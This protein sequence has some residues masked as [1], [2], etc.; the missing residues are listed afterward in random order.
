[1]N[2]FLLFLLTLALTGCGGTSI[3]NGVAGDLDKDFGEGGQALEIYASDDTSDANVSPN[4][5][6]SLPDD[7]I[8]L[9][10][11]VN[12]AFLL[13]KFTSNGVVDTT[14]GTN[15]AAITVFPQGFCAGVSK[16]ILTSDGQIMAGGSVCGKMAI[17]RYNTDGSLDNTYGNGVVAGV[18]IENQLVG[19][20]LQAITSIENS[21]G[22]KVAFGGLV[23]NATTGRDMMVGRLDATG[24]IDTTFGSAGFLILDAGML[25]T[26]I[27]LGLDVN[28]NGEIIAGG[29]TVTLGNPP[30]AD[31]IIIKVTP[32]GSLNTGFGNGGI[33]IRDLS[34]NT[35]LPGPI[36]GE[37][38]SSIKFVENGS[39]ITSGEAGI[40][41]NLNI[42]A[43]KY[44]PDGSIDSNFGIQNGIFVLPSPGN[45][46]VGRLAL[47]PDGKILLSGLRTNING[48]MGVKVF[49]LTASGFPDVSFGQ[50]GVTSHPIFETNQT[51]LGH[52]IAL[53][54]DGKILLSG[55]ILDQS[56]PEVRFHLI[57]LLGN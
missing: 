39:F 11:S 32:Q 2:K 6:L 57:R 10:G 19:P 29:T 52:D 7:S 14:F 17:A 12:G 25:Q 27:L 15:G 42:F 38:V 16:L 24:N 26:D 37:Y 33:L 20:T 44:L 55:I 43:A 30:T 48:T 21:P 56:V 31:Q 3:G 4:A 40:N 53:Q 34:T 1:M 36:G 5:I 8:V 41:A 51:A 35:S 46:Q 22:G 49:R 54:T 9:G 13:V 50:G 23:D 18:W 47:Q 45:D 28:S